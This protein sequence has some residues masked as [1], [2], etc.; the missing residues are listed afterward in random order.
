MASTQCRGPHQQ[1]SAW[2]QPTA[3]HHAYAIAAAAVTA[4][5][6]YR[7]TSLSPNFNI[8]TVGFASFHWLNFV[9][10]LWAWEGGY[11]TLFT[12]CFTLL[13]PG[14]PRR[15][16]SSSQ[17]PVSMVLNLPLLKSGLYCQGNFLATL[18]KTMVK[19]NTTTL[20]SV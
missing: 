6:L 3:H 5:T 16:E 12:K 18:Q 20:D 14:T 8:F 10:E 4:C 19:K 1:W 7:G 11:L 2:A 13:L 15:L 17:Q 9:S